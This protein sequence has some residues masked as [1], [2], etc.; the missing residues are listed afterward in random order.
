[1]P[2]ELVFTSGGTEALHLAAHALASTAPPAVVLVDPGAHPALR[3]AVERA[4]RA[5]QIP[6]RALPPDP[7]GRV[8]AH[9]LASVLASSPKPALVAL[10]WVQHETGAITPLREAIDT[11]RAHD[12]RVLLDAVQAFGKLPVD[13]G[14]TG[15]VAAALSAHKIG[16]P[17]GVG[18]AWIRHDQ[19]ARALTD[20]GAQER[21]LRAGTENTLG[22]IGFAAAA[23]DL[24]SRLAA[25]PALAALR[26]AFEARVLRI[27]G[28]RS[29]AQGAPR[30]ATAA[31]FFVRDVAGEELVAAM[32]LEGVCVSS[33]PACSSGRGGL[34]E[35]LRAMFPGRDAE[36]SGALRVTLGPETTEA[37]LDD[38][39]T[40]LERV[41]PRMRAFSG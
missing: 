40:A 2:R 16:G 20:G 18:A 35:A 4:A 1:M 25:M 3:A 15:A 10:T 33:G 24:G 21:G 6:T 37:M 7:W 9:T 11:A 34:S 22:A 27:E 38:A 36:V 30:V 28:V 23:S 41:I 13:L 32:D 19:P 8:D 5:L 14:A 12:A 31:H 39:A 29:S 17:A 26:D